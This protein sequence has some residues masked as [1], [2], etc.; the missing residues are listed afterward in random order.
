MKRRIE[1]FIFDCIIYFAAFGW[2]CLFLQIC[3][4]VDKWI[5]L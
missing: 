1:N 5:G 3:A 4:H 2:T